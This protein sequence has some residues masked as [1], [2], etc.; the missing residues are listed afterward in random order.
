MWA[1]GIDLQRVSLGALIISLG[2]LVDDAMIAVEMM[3]VR[4]E[5][6]WHSLKAASFAYTSTAFPMLTGTLITAVAFMPVGFAKSSAGEYTFSIFAVVAIAVISSWFVAV[7]FTP[8]LGFLLLKPQ[9]AKERRDLYR[10]RF[11]RAFRRLVTWCV[12]WRKTV[13]LITCIIFILSLWAFQFVEQQFFPVSDRNEVQVELWLPEGSSFKLI[14]QEVR[15]IEQHLN[16]DARIK[17]YVSYVGGGI[18][19]FFIAAFG[20]LRHLNYAAVVITAENNQERDAIY[21]DAKKWLPIDFPHIKTRVT[22]FENGP[23]VVNPIQFRVLG[24]DPAVLR[25]I[26][27]KMTEILRSHPKTYGIYSPW[28]EIIKTVKLEV[29]QDK[30]RALGVSS[31]ELGDNINAMLNG[32]PVTEFRERDQLIEVVVRAGDVD[33]TRLNSLDGLGIRTASGKYVPLAQLVNI[34]Y[35]FEVGKSWHRNGEAQITVSADVVDDAQALDV[36]AS[37]QPKIDAFALTLPEGY[38]IETGGVFE[39]N[40]KSQDSIAAVIP[41]MLVVIVTLLMVQLQKFSGALRVLIS[42]PLGIIGVTWALILFEAPFGFV[43]LLGV[44]ALAGIIIRNSVILVEQIERLM[45]SSQHPRRAIIEATVRRLRPI[46]LTAAATMLAMIPLMQSTFW[47]PMAISMMGG[48]FF[49]T[50]LTLVFEPAMYAAWFRIR[51]SETVKAKVSFKNNN[52]DNTLLMAAESGDLQL[53]NTLLK[54]RYKPNPN[55][56]DL[57]GNSVLML[58]SQNGHERICRALLEAGADVNMVKDKGKT[59]AL[60]RAAMNGHNDVCRLLLK[61]GANANAKS[62]NISAIDIA[63]RRGFDDVVETLLAFGAI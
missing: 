40:L 36:T 31:Q 13:L 6:G 60:M 57:E 38:R 17:Q 43:A 41:M 54:A 42:A 46:L 49:A 39:A 16:T 27:D 52:K 30:A 47:R 56:L 63:T 11:F 50:L 25:G 44:V 20:E 58:A 7:I 1:F 10:S 18:P 14:E 8:Y 55:M 19:H 29:D 23:P 3:T 45:E 61:A 34:E 5:Q 32:Q 48:I 35:G 62:G 21:R 53:L 2:L 33:R 51:V 59:T 37:L 22:R 9:H 28:N 4:M 26:A 12:D 24:D 15:A